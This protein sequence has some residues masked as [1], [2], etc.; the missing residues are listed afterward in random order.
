MLARGERP[1]ASPLKYSTFASV[2]RNDTDTRWPENCRTCTAATALVDN[3][4]IFYTVVWRHVGGT[5]GVLVII[6]VKID[7]HLV[8]LQTKVHHDAPHHLE[9]FMS[10]A[11]RR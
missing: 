10:E 4:Q 2:H 8:K 6:M 3:G 7:Q 9:F 1:T 5:V 11:A